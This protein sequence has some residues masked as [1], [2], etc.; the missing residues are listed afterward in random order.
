MA[1]TETVHD[2]VKEYYGRTLQSSQDLK[3]GC[4]TGDAPPSEHAS[5]IAMIDDEIV[6]RFYGCGS[7]IPDVLE[8]LTVVDLGCGTGRDCY[9]LSHLVGASGSVIGIDMTDE[10]LDVAK[11]Y[12]DGIMSKFGYDYPNVDF[13]K[14]FIEDLAAVGIEENSVDLIISNCV[15]NLSPQKDRVFSEIFRILRPGGELYFSDV[16]CD[17]RIPD[18]LKE[19]PIFHG[20]CLGGALYEEDFRRL[21]ASLGCPDYRVMERSPIALDNGEIAQQAGNIRFTSMTIRAFKLANM[22]DRCEDYGQIA[23]YK[24]TIAGHRHTYK[25]DEEHVFETGKSVAVCGNTA[26]MLAETRF[27]RHFTVLG[28]RSTHYGPFECSASNSSPAKTA[29][30]SED[31]AAAASSSC[32]GSA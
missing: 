31:A 9:L 27:A 3:T 12:R 13:R 28:D 10:Q 1:V 19:D 14:G 7:P 22:E 30:V 5:I 26:S 32:C 6:S 15:L 18:A 16:Y 20:E 29:P 8:G 11:R 21:L 17:R 23:A 24:G 2:H 4:C 25:V